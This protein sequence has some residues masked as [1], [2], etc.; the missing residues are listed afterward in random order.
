MKFAERMLRSAN[1]ES[2]QSV[3]CVKIISELD[4]PLREFGIKAKLEG[5]VSD[6]RRD[7]PLREFGI[8]AKPSIP[9]CAGCA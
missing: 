3:K 1:L 9:P 6:R 7:A 2:R 5:G 8:K 4:A